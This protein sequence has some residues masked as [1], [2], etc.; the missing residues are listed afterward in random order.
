VARTREQLQE[1][2]KYP[3]KGVT[4]EQWEEAKKA[5]RD[6][7]KFVPVIVF[8]FEGI[9]NR[10]DMQVCCGQGMLGLGVRCVRAR[11]M[12]SNPLPALLLTFQNYM[13]KTYEMRVRGDM[14]KVAY[15]GKACGERAS[16]AVQLHAARALCPADSHCSCLPYVSSFFA[17][18]P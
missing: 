13:E 9:K 12:L 17:I 8:G 3:P 5:N 6:P 14:D 4:R 15:C 7:E 11:C 10:V 1:D 2:L 18:S 16:I